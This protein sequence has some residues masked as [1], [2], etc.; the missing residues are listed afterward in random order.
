LKEQ[1]FGLQITEKAVAKLAK[2]GYD[3]VYGA[4]PLRRLIQTV[5][6]NPIAL[7][8]ISKK[9]S[10]GDTIVIDYNDN[11]NEFAFNKGGASVTEKS[12]SDEQFKLILQ[13][14]AKPETV[15][16]DSDK[17]IYTAIHDKVVSA[18]TGGNGTATEI[19]SVTG[20]TA[21]TQIQKIR[22]ELEVAK[23]KGDAL[24]GEILALAATVAQQV[25][26]TDRDKKVLLE[27]LH[28]ELI[29]DA[30]KKLRY[31]ATHDKIVEASQQQNALAVAIL[32]VTDASTSEAIAKIMD[33]LKKGKD[34]EEDLATEILNTINTEVA[35]EAEKA[36][37][38]EPTT[39]FKNVLKQ[40]INPLYAADAE[41]KQKFSTL[42]EK[43]QTAGAQN[44]PIASSILTISDMTSD[45]D[46]Q[47]LEDQLKQAKQQGDPLASEIIDVIEAAIKYEGVAK[48]KELLLNIVNPIAAKT[49][50][51]RE[52]F[53]TLQA[54]V[55]EANQKGDPLAAS[56]MAVTEASTED[57]VLQI[58]Q[59]LEQ[60]AEQKNELAVILLD[61]LNG[62]QTDTAQTADGQPQDPNAPDPNYPFGK[63][64]SDVTQD[65]AAA[66]QAGPAG[67][68]TMPVA[69]VM[70]GMPVAP[71][72]QVVAPMAPQ[73]PVQPGYAAVP[74]APA[75]FAP[76]APMMPVAPVM[77]A[78][79]QPAMAPAMPQPGVYT[80]PMQPV[81]GPAP[82]PMQPMG[83]GTAAMPAG[84]AFGASTVSP[85]YP[86][87]MNEALNNG[88]GTGATSLEPKEQ[89]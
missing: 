86:P 64:Q 44:H 84:T 35:E 48:V 19:L 5:I 30:D 73:M 50:V 23:E 52:V 77:S 16:G 55:S 42:Y 12:L 51:E 66:Q 1:G 22:T 71:A 80:A 38:A 15:S 88:V 20:A 74:V 58:K 9:F 7:A 59:Q 41:N 3:P 2:D 17:G 72:G 13:K 32:A 43:I 11:L 33:D 87:V 65:P 8:I 36:A 47:Q 85:A 10:V 61:A 62:T 78:P 28:P 29:K 81:M 18:S 4:R 67:D 34:N 79:M 70:P 54:K 39:K 57:E 63:A 40:V 83:G 14:I 25:A 60:G 75:A 69:P 56:I 24:A 46:I 27:L 45:S 37:E 53:T 89:S 6:E 82:V 31:T 76:Q 21:I 49:P 26:V 68:P